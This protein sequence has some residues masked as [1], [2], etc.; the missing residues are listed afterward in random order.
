MDETS[1]QSKCWQHSYV[2]WWKF[3]NNTYILLDALDE[4]I[5]RE[6]VL[7]FVEA[8]MGWGIHDL[9]VLAT[10]RKK[11]DIDTFLEPL[12]PCQLDI[13][14]ALVGPD[15]RLHIPENLIK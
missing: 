8:L 4:C 2:N 15:S 6:D 9:H 1:P 5:N 10:S 3:S 14:S 12:V 13:Q 11:N 7:Q